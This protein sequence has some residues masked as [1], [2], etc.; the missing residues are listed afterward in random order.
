MLLGARGGGLHIGVCCR[1]CLH[2]YVCVF[3]RKGEI[4]RQQE[5]AEAELINAL[6]LALLYKTGPDGPEF[7]SQVTLGVAQCLQSQ[8]L[9]REVTGSVRNTCQW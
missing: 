6:C 1:R 5:Q 7:F 2:V 9:Q 8:C 3:E 4:E